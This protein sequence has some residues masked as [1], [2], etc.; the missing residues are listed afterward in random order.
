MSERLTSVVIVG[1]RGRM[2]QTLLRT[3]MESDTMTLVGAVDRTGGPGLDQD[4]GRL[5]GMPEIGVMVSDTMSPPRGAVVVDFSLPRATEHNIRRCL[6]LRAPLVLGTTGIS[7]EARA[8]LKEAA[9]EIPIVS[10]ANFSVGVTLMIRLAALAAK[11]LG[12]EWEAELFELHH[13]HKRDAPSG[14]ALRIGKA[15]AAANGRRLDDV[16][17]MSREKTE[18]ARTAD[19]IGVMSLRGGNSV[20]EHTLMFFGEGERIELTHRA[21]DRAIFALGALRAARWVAGRAPGL[22]DMVDV[23]DLGRL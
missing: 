14:T 7:T 16:A 23:L 12:P 1:A 9:Q 8:L 6:E 20:G 3:V 17:V 2:G 5:C 19:E 10:A 11:S 21:M 18:R 15:V 13:R 4:A 22:Y